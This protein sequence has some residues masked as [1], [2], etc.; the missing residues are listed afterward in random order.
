MLSENIAGNT[1]FAFILQQKDAA[2]MA[3]TAIFFV[4]FMFLY[5]DVG[6]IL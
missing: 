2:R 5:R 4:I 1:G 6:I 3:N